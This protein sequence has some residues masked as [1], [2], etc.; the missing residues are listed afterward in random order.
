MI[1]SPDQIKYFRALHQ[2][3]LG[4]CRG[5]ERDEYHLIE[6]LQKIDRD[7]AYR[8]FGFKSLIQY[9]EI[10]L[11]LDKGRAYNFITVARKA[12]EVERLQVALKENKIT[13]S[14]AKRISSVINKDNADH[15]LKLS[16]D[17][18][19]RLLERAVA[20]VNPKSAV[21]EGSNLYLRIL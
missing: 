16:N 6:V 4:V 17:L 19:Q 1:I 11:K 2:E 21:E 13:L 5:L 14:K 15:W 12:S 20:R 7:K 3:A 9:A 10:G 18:S 8:F